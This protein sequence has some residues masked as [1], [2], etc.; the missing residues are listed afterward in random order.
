MTVTAN[1]SN[2]RVLEA[3]VDYFN[4]FGFAVVGATHSGKAGIYINNADQCNISGN[5]ASE[6]RYGI[7][8]NSSSNSMLTNNIANSN[9]GD[10]GRGGRGLDIDADGGL[11]GESV[12]RF[13]LMQPWTG[14]TPPKGDCD[15]TPADAAIAL[16][17]AASGAQNSAADVSSDGSITYIDALMILRAATGVISL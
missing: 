4:I 5:N 9:S 6:N 13:P 10:V 7:Y 8:L 3:T 15:G 11:G 1:S 16:R 17:L 14:G 2:G 12:D